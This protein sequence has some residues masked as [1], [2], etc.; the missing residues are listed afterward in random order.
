[1]ETIIL[2]NIISLFLLLVFILSTGF[3]FVFLILHFQG[4]FNGY[5]TNDDLGEFQQIIN[6]F[7]KDKES[8]SMLVGDTAFFYKTD[9]P[10]FGWRYCTYGG[11]KISRYAIS[12]NTHIARI[13]N[14]RYKIK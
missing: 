14:E 6:D 10:F 2:I 7:K 8:P 4:G 3:S 13:L 1:M 5:L 9:L 12:N 11:G